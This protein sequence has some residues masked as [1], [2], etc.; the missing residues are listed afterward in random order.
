MPKILHF[1]VGNFHRAHQAWYTAQANAI[2]D[3]Q[4]SITGVSLRSAGIRD[5]LAS[6]NFEYTLVI[7]DAQSVDC[8]T[9]DVIDDI[10]VAAE[11]AQA[12][13][14]A[15]A[16]PQTAV[17]TL[18][19][20][21]KGYHLDPSD[22]GLNL[23]DPAISEDLG[24]GSPKTI[25][26]FLAEGL[27]RRRERG[28]AALNIVSCD[29]LPDNGSKLRRALSSYCTA[30]EIDLADYPERGLAFAN[31][32]VDRI[33][34]ATD[35]ALR[36]EVFA[37]TGRRDAHPVSTEV[38]TEWYIEDVLHAPY[39]DWA[40]VG[41]RLVKD[42]EPFEL[43]KLRLLNGSH[44]LLAYAGL[45]AGYVYVHEAVGDPTIRKRVEQLMAEAT[46]TLPG[47]SRTDAT[48]YCRALFERFEN[49]NLNHRLEQIAMDGSL[50][51]PIRI[52]PVIRELEQ[53][54]CSAEAAHGAMV[55]WADYVIRTVRLSGELNDP[56]SS[57]MTAIIRQSNDDVLLHN[58]LLQLLL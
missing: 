1:G 8:R 57:E 2:S 21:E 10:L 54:G 34:P 15:I 45:L 27:R 26:G 48:G 49:P 39:P 28:G 5:R 38:F 56:K 55:T 25:Y 32:M 42:V 20:T 53:L 24:S 30:A 3:E 37:R 18:T 12:V 19:V 51:L 44:S 43:R 41:A 11:N 35:D 23:S 7:K 36:D 17:V 6:Q 13:V 22:G 50:K 14:E 4:W 46:Q 40:S 29:N 16:D 31:T 33:V 52:V 47:E 9:I 58:R